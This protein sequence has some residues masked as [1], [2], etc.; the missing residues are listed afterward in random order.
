MRTI[1]FPLS[2]LL[3]FSVL[4]SSPLFAQDSSNET[5]Q[6]GVINIVY[7]NF[8]TVDRAYVLSHIRLSEGGLYNRLLSDQSLRSL[9]NTNYFEFVDFRITEVEGITELN[10]HLTAKYKLEQLQF[11]G[12]ENFSAKRLLEEG[13]IQELTILDEYLIDSAAE[14]ISALYSEKGYKDTNVTYSIERDSISGKATVYFTIEEGVKISLKAISFNGVSAFNPKVLNRLMKTKNKD[15]FSWLS[16]SGKFDQSLFADDLDQLRLFY[17]NAGFLDIAINPDLVDYDFTIPQKGRITISVEE[18]EQYYLGSVG[19]EGASI[20]TNQELLGLLKLKKIDGLVYSP[21][22]VD[23]WAVEIKDFYSSRGYLETMVFADKKSNLENRQI[24]V[25]FK[26]KESEKYYLESISI[27]GNTKTQQKVIIRELALKPGDVFDFKRM[28]SSEKRLKNSAFFDEVRLRPEATN[29]PGRKN[30][31][32]FVSESRTGSFSFGAGF[33]SVRSSQFFLEMKQS[34]FDINDWESGFQGAGQKFRARISIGRLTKQA[35]LGFE[36]PWLFEQRIAFGTNLYS[37][38]SEYNSS[39]YNEKRTGLELYIRRRLFELVEAKLSYKYEMVDIYDVPFLGDL[40]TPDNIADVFQI[41][42]GEQTVS[43]IGLTVL[44]DNRDSLLFTRSGN[45][46]SIDTEFAGLG[47]D[48]DYFK[49]DFRTAQFIPTFDTLKQSLSIIGR[50][51]TI[52]ALKDDNEAPFYDRFYL[53]GPETLRGYDY[54]DI[55]PLSTDGVDNLGAVNYSNETSGG[56]TYGLIST[57]YMFQV[58][59]GFGLVAFYD[60]GFVNEE[61]KDFGFDDYADNFGVGARL[62]MMGSPLKL[63]YA[64]PSN[65]PDHLPNSPQFH[66]SFGTR[67]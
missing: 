56:H 10:I 17:R 61:E 39:D 6:L 49:V 51:G 9:Y 44:R 21:S 23:A 45:R 27:E 55:G 24:D 47:G 4:I 32:V 18:G 41:A 2:F 53:G 19:V 8:K 67:Y 36:E 11:S 60:G 3:F 25:V 22:I 62:L 46:T 31:S 20:F 7:E 12:N 43:K 37:T 59:D 28:Q 15:F 54:R 58:S 5:V 1:R 42:V 65:K 26:I 13:D 48:I 30:L 35:L 50:F 29:I 66:F 16:G 34:N 38:E 63:D 40:S 64:I 52:L 57:E 14:K 33:G